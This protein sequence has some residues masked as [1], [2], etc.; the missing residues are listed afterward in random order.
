MKELTLDWLEK[1]KACEEAIDEFKRRFGTKAKIK[2]VVDELHRIKRSDWEAWLLAQTLPLTIAMIEAG[3][4]VHAEND[5]ALCWVA[6]FYNNL[7]ILKYLVEHDANIHAKDD[8]AL[9][10]SAERGHFN[11]VKYLVENGA[12]VHAR[13]NEALC[14]ATYRRHTRTA[15]FLAEF[16]E[17]QP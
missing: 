17:R 13:N 6:Y 3:A 10:Y 5:L 15:E 1:Y 11:I 16:L 4:N 8:F 14:W 9:R 7:S 2:D 12:N